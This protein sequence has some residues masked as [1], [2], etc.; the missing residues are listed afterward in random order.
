MNRAEEG[1]LREA[2]ARRYAEATR[3]W[4]RKARKQSLNEKKK[5]TEKDRKK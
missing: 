1:K 4:Q 3:R 5:E 2:M